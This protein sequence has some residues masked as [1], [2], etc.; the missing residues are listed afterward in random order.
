MVNIQYQ[1]LK[2]KQ[3]FLKS[4]HTQLFGVHFP[5][6]DKN[7]KYLFKEI[8]KQKTYYF[9]S[10]SDSPV[11]ID[12]GAN[13]G[14]SLVYFKTIFPQAK[15]LAIEASPNTFKKLSATLKENGY[16]DVTL[17]NCALSDNDGSI[18]FYEADDNE[19]LGNSIFKRDG[20]KSMV[21]VQA[22][23]LSAMIEQSV[24]F[25]KIDIEG[26]EFLVLKDLHQSGKIHL[27]EQGVIEFHHIEGNSLEAI[28]EILKANHFSFKVEKSSKDTS[29]IH[30]SKSK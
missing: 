25:I 26:A 13:V 8:F 3:S 30:F 24:D 22:K 14:M 29:L 11:I 20:L 7:W 18:D 2:L 15:I 5:T 21:N 4:N 9:K 16:S 1:V 27:I 12:C 17:A 19:N 28:L 6:F 10:N 23:K